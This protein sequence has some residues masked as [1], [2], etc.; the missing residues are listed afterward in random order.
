MILASIFRLQYGPLRDAW[1]LWQSYGIFRQ[2]VD[3]SLFLTGNPLMN[4][5]HYIW[6]FPCLSRVICTISDGASPANGVL[7]FPREKEEK[8]RASLPSIF[9][10]ASP[11]EEL[12]CSPL[13][14][15]KDFQIKRF[16]EH[17]ICL[18]RFI[19]NTSTLKSQKSCRKN[20][21]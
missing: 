14:F 5:W 8:R 7:P 6:S 3:F 15:S 4:T 9:Q 16:E 20:S 1:A 13:H 10:A 19:M 21:T 2:L 12:H 11:C 18:W 17:S